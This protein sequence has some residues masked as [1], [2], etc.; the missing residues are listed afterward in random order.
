MCSWSL[1]ICTVCVSACVKTG[2]QPG[3]ICLLRDLPK[4]GEN[5]ETSGVVGL[6]WG[7][8]PCPVALFSCAGLN[9]EAGLA[10]LPWA[11]QKAGLR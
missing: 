10:S 7:A 1:C 3:S 5:V 2:F 9:E 4:G 6:Q 8:Q 11:E